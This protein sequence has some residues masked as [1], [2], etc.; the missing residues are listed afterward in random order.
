MSE[1]E[2]IIDKYGVEKIEKMCIQKRM[3][4]LEDHLEKMERTS[5]KI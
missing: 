4:R 3:K 1:I 5:K 2:A